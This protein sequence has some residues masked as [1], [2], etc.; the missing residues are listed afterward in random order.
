MYIVLTVS[1]FHTDVHLV[2]L[3]ILFDT[4]ILS[5]IIS[6]SNM[7]RW[8]LKSSE[9]KEPFKFHSSL[10]STYLFDFCMFAASVFIAMVNI[11]LCISFDL[12]KERTKERQNRSSVIESNFLR[13]NF[14]P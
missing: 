6:T 7:F 8:E 5:E 4:T 13:E 10:K 2:Y 3:V 11:F 9:S 14:E 12:Q 1:Q